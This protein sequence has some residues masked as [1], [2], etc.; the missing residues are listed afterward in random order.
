MATQN[1]I[2][3]AYSSTPTATTIASWDANSNLSANNMISGYTTTA[4]AAATTTLTVS[5]NQNQ[6]FT[7]STTQTLV[8]PVTSTLVLGQYWNIVNLSSGVVTIQSS[9]GNTILA[10]PAMSETAVTCILTSGTSAASWTTSPA[11]SGSGTVNSGT[12]NDLAYYAANGTAV[13]ALAT[14]NNGVLVTDGSGVPSISSTLPNSLALG[15]PASGTLT[16]C[17]DS[18]FAKAWV[19]FHWTGAA[20][21]VD[22]G[23]NIASVTRGGTGNYTVNFTNNMADTV[24]CV[25]TGIN[26]G[27]GT[28]AMNATTLAVGSFKIFTFTG[29]VA[30]DP[31]NVF[32]AVYD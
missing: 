18:R 20:I 3:R 27:S 17:T 25:V 19:N 14:A 10:L 30:F 2:E 5:S 24:Y 28:S 23:F 11:V 9:G 16:N 15:T 21:V 8:M 29:G 22:K 31:T 26:S 1:T 6:Y 12:I 13:S 32:A 4:T 7:G